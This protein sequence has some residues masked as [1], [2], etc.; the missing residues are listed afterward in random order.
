MELSQED[1]ADILRLLEESQFDQLDLEIGGLRL[2]VRRGEKIS[3][4]KI[5]TEPATES[6]AAHTRT[7]RAALP[8]EAPVAGLVTI[9]APTVGTFYRAPQPDAPPFVEIG[10]PVGP[11]TP[12]A[13]I[14]VMKLTNTVPAGVRGVI[15]EVCVENNQMVEYGQ[16][17]FRVR[18]EP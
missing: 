12:V 17:L 10:A 18:P 4:D 9:T 2:Q 1:V 7:E 3:I 8:P 15:V 6:G 13:V 11:E 5:S 16:P 14:E